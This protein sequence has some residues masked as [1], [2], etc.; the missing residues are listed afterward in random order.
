MNTEVTLSRTLIINTRSRIS[1]TEGDFPNRLHTQL[2]ALSEYISEVWSKCKTS[3]SNNIFQI[4]SYQF[5]VYNNSTCVHVF[6]VN[7]IIEQVNSSH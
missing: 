5:F 1:I 3:G 7:A 6:I 2:I 4:S